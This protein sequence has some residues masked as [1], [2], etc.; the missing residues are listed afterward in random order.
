MLYIIIC[1]ALQEKRGVAA[2]VT[3]AGEPNTPQR[4]QAI[5]RV[6]CDCVSTNYACAGGLEFSRA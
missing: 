2:E 5:M 3:K 6:C 4:M 1:F